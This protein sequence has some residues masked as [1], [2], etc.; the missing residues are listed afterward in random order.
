MKKTYLIPELEIVDVQYADGILTVTSGEVEEGT[1]DQNGDDER[2][3][4]FVF[5]FDELEW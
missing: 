3:G 5:G 2:A 1:A 4:E